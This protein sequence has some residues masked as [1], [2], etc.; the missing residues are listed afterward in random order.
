MNTK[1]SK[2]RAVKEK[3]KAQTNESDEDFQASQSIWFSNSNNNNPATTTD[4][5][6]QSHKSSKR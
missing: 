1:T 4:S 5:R 3:A 2:P 6:I